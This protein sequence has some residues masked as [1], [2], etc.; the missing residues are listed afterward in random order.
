MGIPS[1][2]R[3]VYHGRMIDERAIRRRYETMR[4]GLDER[5]RRLLAAAEARTAGYGGVS[6][7]ARA[8]GIARSTIGRGLKELEALDLAQPKVRR[9]GGGRPSLAQIDPTLLEDLQRLLDP[10]T[11]GDPMRPLVWVSKSHAKLAA[12]LREMGHQVSASRIPKLLERLCYRR[13][14]NRKTK[15]GSH[16]PDRDAQF[17]HINKQIMALQA[18]GQP[19]ISV[20][21]KKKE[22]IGEYKN[23]GSD[24]RPEGRPDEVNVHD[25]VDKELG[26]AIPYGVY[27]IAADA[28]CVSVGIDHDTAEFAVSAIGRWQETMGCE[29]Y[30][31]ADR[32][33]ITADGGG[34]NGSRVR[35]WKIE[36]QKLADATGLT[37]VV[38]HYPPG[39]SKWNKIEHRLFCH[40][41]QNWRGRPLTSRLAVV[42]LIA[43]TTTKTGLKVR[44]ELD[45]KTYAKGIKVTDAQ[46]ATLNIKGDAFHPE[47]NYTISPRS[48]KAST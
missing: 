39:T 3:D 37:L 8:T 14:V 44:C 2:E 7:V 28:G 34:S 21:T 30:P 47:W 17:E 29:R 40:I 25:F 5:A 15:E 27:D 19:V 48:P 33:M 43:A 38:C 35:L 13:Q 20:D 18:A 23:A 4:P 1:F 10:A 36:L 24:Y 11:V 46:M 31:T 45:T 41:T 9:A 12:A 32:L 16:H 6:A 26:K 42:E 22:L